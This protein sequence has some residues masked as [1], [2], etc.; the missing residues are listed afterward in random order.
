MKNVKRFD[1]PHQGWWSHPYA[2]D[3]VSEN[4]WY[5]SVWP[6]AG[7]PAATEKRA[8]DRLDGNGFFG[9]HKRAFD[10]LDT[11]AFFFNHNKKREATPSASIGD[12]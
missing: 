1:A 9:L 5:Y 4:D 7:E 3:D 11:S 6:S 12:L 8:F 2:D 10:R